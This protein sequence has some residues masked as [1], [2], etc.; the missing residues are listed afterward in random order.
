MDRIKASVIDKLSPQDKRGLALYWEVFAENEEIINAHIVRAVAKFPDVAAY[1]AS[2]PVGD[3]A[4]QRERS[5]INL[6]LA[7]RD[8]KWDPLVDTWT[9]AGA[10]LAIAAIS[11][12]SWHQVFSTSREILIP[13]LYE[14]YGR[15]PEKYQEAIKGM[16]LY[17]DIGHLIISRAWINAK[18]DIIRQEEQEL[19]NME[20]QLVEADKLAIAGR[21]A[22]AVAHEVNN[23]LEAIKNALHVALL[24]TPKASQSHKLLQLAEAETKRIG[25][26]VKRM[27]VLTPNGTEPV[28]LSIDL[29]QAVQNALLL[30]GPELTTRGVKTQTALAASLPP[31]LADRGQLEQV[32]LNL[33]LNAKDAM[34]EGGALLITTR[35]ARADEKF[36]TPGPHVVVEVNDTGSGISDEDLR[37]V[38]EP[39]FSTKREGGNVGIGLWVTQNIVHTLG[40]RIKAH[41]QVGV[42]TTFTVALPAAGGPPEKVHKRPARR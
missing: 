2:R 39:F 31:I 23:P 10:R 37:Q 34:Q 33:M 6:R 13:A 29:N 9:S 22:A 35:L 28:R 17:L 4:A 38:F 36:T 26:I 11:L 7:L 24:D 40:G 5:R 14:A 16:D 25:G 42:G 1:I 19:R 27:M 8:G 12:E 18:E 3:P 20:L 21:L 30:L 15:Q 32:F 41:S